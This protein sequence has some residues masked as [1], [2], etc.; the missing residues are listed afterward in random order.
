MLGLA[1]VK[2]SSR[3]TPLAPGLHALGQHDSL[4]AAS[5]SLRPDERLAVFLDDL[6][7]VTLPERAAPIMGS[8]PA[9]LSEVQGSR[10]TSARRGF[11]TPKEGMRHPAST[12]W[13][14]TSGA[15]TWPRSSV[16]S[17]VPIG[18]PDFVN[19]QAANRLVQ[20]PDVQCAWL[21][22]AFCAAP[23]AQHLERPEPA[24]ASLAPCRRLWF[25]FLF[26]FFVRAF[27]LLP[28]ASVAFREAA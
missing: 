4:V 7:V 16:S 3:V 20:L 9:R 24:A 15:A 8:S 10:P 18:H 23:R 28:W 22:L 19:A 6:Y 21:L 1:I 26:F 27:F 17:C 13:A 5:A 2:V 12:S 25:F 14:R 11:S